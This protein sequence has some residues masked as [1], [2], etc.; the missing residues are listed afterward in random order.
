MDYFWIQRRWN[1]FTFFCSNFGG[2]F[3]GL[4]SWILF[5]GSIFKTLFAVR[6]SISKMGKNILCAKLNNFSG[7]EKSLSRKNKLF[8]Q[9]FW[10]EKGK[11]VF[12]TT[13]L[14]NFFRIQKLNTVFPGFWTESKKCAD[15]FW[16]YFFKYLLF[17]VEKLLQQ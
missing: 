16:L 4:S 8:G 6:E 11:L 7:Q 5:L 13:F 14:Y 1:V 17:L 2:K 10:T 12:C 15:I 9:K 3:S